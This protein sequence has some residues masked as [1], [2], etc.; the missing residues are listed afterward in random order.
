MKWDFCYPLHDEPEFKREEEVATET[1]T[2]I[3]KD[4][5]YKGSQH[6]TQSGELCQIWSS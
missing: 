1:V 5:Y 4:K 3:N 6:K 2:G